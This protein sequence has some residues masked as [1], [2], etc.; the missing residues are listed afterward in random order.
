MSA[1]T[2]I[3]VSSPL[4]SQP[5]AEEVIRQAISATEAFFEPTDAE[6]SILLCNDAEIRR[7]NGEWR[8]KDSATNVLSFPAASSAVQ[9][10]LGDIAIAYE[11]VAR[12]AAN[13]GKPFAHHLVH[14]TIHG[15]LHLLGFD[16]EADEDAEEM[17]N[18][19]REILAGL[20]IADPYE[21]EHGAKR[22]VR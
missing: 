20:G 8:G 4:W 17:E 14:L 15:Y 11:T 19:E 5:E 16:H 3:V 9:G 22:A 6:V 18:L 10:H 1:Q 21:A 12:E 13:D 7:L 2:E